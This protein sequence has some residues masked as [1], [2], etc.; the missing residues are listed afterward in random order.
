[1]LNT[2][3]K[4]TKAFIIGKRDA[5]MAENIFVSSCTLPKR[6]T[7][8]NARINLTNQSGISNGPKSTNDITTMN[9]SSQFQPLRMNLN[10]QFANMFTQSSIAKIPVKM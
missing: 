4:I 10:G 5:V 8:L 9:K 7:T 6:R 3:I 1:M 2:M